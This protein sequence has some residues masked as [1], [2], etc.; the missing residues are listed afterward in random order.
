[1][2][3]VGV[4]QRWTALTTTEERRPSSLPISHTRWPLPSLPSVLSV[5]ARRSKQT[6]Q[7]LIKSFLQASALSSLH[8]I[9]FFHFSLFLLQADYW[10]SRTSNTGKKVSNLSTQHHLSLF[11]RVRRPGYSWK[12]MNDGPSR[13][14]TVVRVWSYG[15]RTEGSLH[16]ASSIMIAIRNHNTITR[17]VVLC[18]HPK[19]YCCEIL[20]TLCLPKIDH[21][22]PSYQSLFL[23][24]LS[25]FVLSFTIPFNFFRCVV[26][27]LM[28]EP[29]FP[30]LP[31]LNLG[32]SSLVRLISL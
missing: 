10:P 31:Q 9:K 26:P 22:G 8:P 16:V 23:A 20:E 29:H 17:C 3:K 18:L 25:H 2:G 11:L 13:P 15:C 28:F 14:C 6:R 32:D 19:H 24:G 4:G 1:M 12:A 21:G 5:H 27:H 7:N 30:V